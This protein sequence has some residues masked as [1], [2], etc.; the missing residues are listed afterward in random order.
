MMSKEKFTL[1]PISAVINFV[2]VL[3]EMIV[4]LV[5]VIAV[6]GFGGE[7]EGWISYIIYIIYAV[8][9][10]AML[11]SGIIKWKRFRYWFEEEEL[12]IEYGL[13]VKKKR[14]IPFERIQSLNY[15]EGIFHRPFGLVKV[16]VETAGGG[17]TK[18]ADAELTAISK[19]AAEQIK[20][21]M[22]LAKNKESDIFDE[23]L[24]P[25]ELVVEQQKPL[26]RMSQKDLLILASTSGGVGVFFSGL[27]VFVSQFSELI[28][29]ETIYNEIILFI[30]FGA[31]L[32]ALSVFFVLF[33]AWIVSVA[34]TFINYYEFT[35]RVEDEEIIITRGLLEK[36]KITIPLSRIQGVR[37]VENP[38]RQL[39]GYATVIVDSA[40][41]S[42][43]EKDEKIRLIPLIKKHKINSIIVQIFPDY[44]FEPSFTR[45]P[46][47]SRKFFY[48]L[49]FL[50][51][52]PVAVAVSYFFYPFGL[53]SLLLFP[54]SFL[55]G[56]WQHKT[57][58]Y[59]MDEKQLVLQYRLF[60]RV[61]LWMEKKRIQAMTER[62]TYFQKKADVSSIMTTIK[63]G[64]SGSA[65]TI[66]HIEKADADSLMEWYEPAKKELVEN[67][68]L[69][70]Y[71]EEI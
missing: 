61:S 70:R 36:K 41:G 3:K 14:Y 23:T 62:T 43:A 56:A 10:I 21:E 13:F 31:L 67:N 55:L 20:K 69:E 5:V 25:E 49:D 27:A 60:S 50:W 37:I 1:H 47:R 17:P 66:Q 44:D 2:K 30:R 46:K 7:S 8:V 71:S 6:N 52:I 32:I 19:D 59:W 18:E 64:V 40:G 24:Q 16:K 22:N 28:P 33:V 26:F 54:L 58:G 39:T 65:T 4:P 11:V 34:I 63:S 57:A 68:M 38:L 9:L 15:T 35:I 51:M 53:L 48:R 42:L 45:V 12:R 29:Y